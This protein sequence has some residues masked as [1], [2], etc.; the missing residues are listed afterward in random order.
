MKYS[1]GMA[2]LYLPFF[3]IA[4]LLAPSLGY[5]ADGFSY[6]YQLA[7][8]LSSLLWALAGLFILRRILLIFFKDRTTALVLLVFAFL[9]NYLEYAAISGAMT[10]NYLF[11][12]YALLVYQSILFHRNP[13]TRRAILI[14]AICGLMT[15][16][17]PSEIISFLI[18][19]LWGID[20][21]KAIQDRFGFL[22]N[23]RKN[24]SLA[25]LTAGV[26]ISIQ[27]IY[28]HQVTGHWVVYS[29]QTDRY[30]FLHPQLVNGLFSFK[31]GWFTYTPVMLAV[32][33]GFYLLYRKRPALFL[34][35]LL[36]ILVFLY[37]CFSWSNW[38]YGGS[39]GQRAI[40]QAYPVLA[41]P[42]AASFE[43]L[44]EK[45]LRFYLAL[46]FLLLFGYYNLW[47]HHQAHRGGLLDPEN[48]TREY[49]MK[50]L[51][52]V[53]SHAHRVLFFYHY[54][55]NR[56]LT[57]LSNLF[58]NLNLTD[59]E[60]GFKAFRTDMIK[61]LDLKEKRFGFEPE[62]TAKVSRIKRVRIYEVGISYY[63]RTYEEGKKIRWKD[64]VKAIYYIIKYNTWG[65]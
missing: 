38:W 1:A 10:H 57:F 55:A 11:T 20:S 23:H 18:P 27:L 32:I 16:V 46:P 39:L 9:T 12:L 43:W 25:L 36:F 61:S 56:F 19:L 14:G 24:I 47:L 8:G 31:K 59:M 26:I 54:L 48:M 45:R 58:T 63:G 2:V 33:P 65:R 21:R 13:S 49:W 51:R 37:L 7:I 41:F 62:V 3:A 6:P 40:V 44:L 5:A 34:A 28:W 15:L 64:G 4:H 22:W 53:G 17:R 42:L 60:T 52:F 29:Y 35:P 30:R 50:I